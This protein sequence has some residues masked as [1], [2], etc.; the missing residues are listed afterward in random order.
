[1]RQPLTRTLTTALIAALVP[2][3][4]ASGAPAAVANPVPASLAAADDPAGKVTW[5]MAPADTDGP[6]GRRTIELDL[7]PGD[8]T[9]EHVAVTN[10]SGTDMTFAVAANDGY[11]TANGSYDLRPADHEPTDAGAWI[12]AATSVDVPSKKTVV[13]PFTVTVPDGATPGD[14]SAGITTSVSSQGDQVSV[15]NRVG[16]RVDVR[17]PGEASAAVA[18][19]GLAAS[20]Q[21]S[22]NPFASGSVAVSATVAATGNVR[23]DVDGTATT[24]GPFGALV[25][26]DAALKVGELLPGSSLA[27]RTDTTDVWPLFRVTTTVTVTPK[28]VLDEATTT[29]APPT[30]EPVT[31]TVVTWAIPWIQI[32]LL[33]AIVMLIV[34]V[35]IDRRARRRR[36]DAML[37]RARAEG[38][39]QAGAPT[40]PA[41][42]ATAPDVPAATSDTR[43]PA[44]PGVPDEARRSSSVDEMFPDQDPPPESR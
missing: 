26:P 20:Y 40:A 42:A 5:S 29:D 22:W 15:D 1:M 4:V 39:A 28:P 19:K 7:G 44:P 11:L 41:A 27:A 38:A 2:V 17:V 31:A 24:E 33:L 9:T 6:D 25:S 23:V 10:S 43:A 8:S 30:A 35:R 18:I 21:P 16:V 14:H 36:L 3:L 34:V 37:A 12:D 13:V 32:L